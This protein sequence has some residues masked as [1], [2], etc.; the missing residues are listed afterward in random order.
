MNSSENAIRALAAA[1]LLAVCAGLAG[2]LVPSHRAA[3]IDPASAL[4]GY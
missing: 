2:A 3:S 1:L 4:S